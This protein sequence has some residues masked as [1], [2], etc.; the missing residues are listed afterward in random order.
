MTQNELILFEM[1]KS[2]TI[3]FLNEILAA[4]DLPKEYEERKRHE[5]ILPQVKAALTWEELTT[6]VERNVDGEYC[7]SAW[8][9]LWQNM[10][11]VILKRYTDGMRR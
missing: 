4:P 7:E 8:Q 9:Y 6:A 3:A 2:S 10:M 1:A 5:W 11:Y